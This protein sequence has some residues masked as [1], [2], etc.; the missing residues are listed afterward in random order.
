MQPTNLAGAVARQARVG[1][2]RDDVTHRGELRQI[3][4]RD[5]ERCG[6][7]ALHDTVQSRQLAALP[8]RGHPYMLLPIPLPWPV[9]KVEN[10]RAV[11]AILGVQ[12]PDFRS[13]RHQQP[14]I[15]GQVFVIGIG[16]VGKQCEGDVCVPIGEILPLHVFHKISDPILPRKQR[17][18]GYQC[19]TV[20]RNSAGEI[21]FHDRPGGTILEHSQFT[22][23]TANWL[24]APA[25]SVTRQRPDQETLVHPSR[26]GQAAAMTMVNNHTAAIPPR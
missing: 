24:A 16:K 1:V 2:Q 21:Q 3:A 25:S 5:A 22:M 26:M 18:D 14:S 11:T 6:V 9:Q 12:P 17:R 19:T 20:G 10:R 15:A 23:L 8:L 13:D 4:D 7:A